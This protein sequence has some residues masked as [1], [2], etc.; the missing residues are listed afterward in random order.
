MLLR[1]H[2]QGGKLL[3]AEQVGSERILRFTV[4]SSSELGFAQ[5]RLL[6]A[7]IMG[8]HSNLIAVDA[9]SGRIIDAIKRVSF[10]MSRVRQVFP[11]QPYALP[12][13]QGKLCLHAADEAALE[14]RLGKREGIQA[15]ELMQ[16]VAGLSPFLAEEICLAAADADV[17]PPAGVPLAPLAR[18]LAAQ[19]LLAREGALSPCVYLNEEG[20]PA[21]FHCFPLR[22]YEGIRQRLDFGSVSEAAEYY[23]SHK[24]ASNRMRQRAQDLSRAVSAAIDKQSLKRQRLLEDLAEAEQSEICRVYGELLTANL[25]ALESGASKARVF[26][27]YSNEEIEIPLD[28]R[29]SPGKN[30]QLYFKKYS[31]SRTALKEKQLQLEENSKDLDYLASVAV[32]LENA[33][34]AETLEGLRQELTEAGFLRRRKENVRR[35]QS[36]L[37]Y[38]RYRTSDGFTLLAGRSNRENDAL[39]FKTADKKDLWFHAKD[40]PGSHVLLQLEGRE[41]TETAIREAAALAAYHSKGRG[42]ENVPVDYV[43]VRHVKKPAGAKPG[44]VIFTDN[45]TV[46]ADPKEPEDHTKDD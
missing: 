10:D 19:S 22:Q 30:A 17:L 5:R 27:Y 32:F 33:K 14:A 18:A 15:K 4:E 44:M 9:E 21:D 26:N 28:P 39:T 29:I 20:V 40:L 35:P 3:G 36:R 45:R 43:S 24:A 2:F 6:Y 41:P 25:H 16:A 7:E 37:Q 38:L 23:Y 11:G 12:P 13:D 1:K 46:Y 8:K 31:K 42:S 34:D